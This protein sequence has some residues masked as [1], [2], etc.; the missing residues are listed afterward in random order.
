MKTRGR[1][2]APAM[3]SANKAIA[4]CA[5]AILACIGAL[6]F[7]DES[8]NDK[9]R[10]GV[11]HSYQVLEKLQT[12]RI[13]INQA[14]AGQRGYMLTG[15]DRYLE[16]YAAGVG[17]VRQDMIELPDLTAD[18]L[19][20]RDAIKRLDP[21]IEARLAELD[22]G[23]EVR[24]RSGLLAGV[25]AVTEGNAGELWME[26]IATHIAEMQQTEAELLNKRLET[27]AVST[28]TMKLVIVCG[29]ALA[30]LILLVKGFVIHWEIGRRN[31]AEQQLKH[32]N[33]RLERRTAQL[34]ETNIELESFAY[35]VA[36]DLRAPLRHIAGYASV[37]AEDYGPRL[38]AEGLRCLGKIGDGAEKMGGLVDDLLSLS[39]VGR[40]QLSRHD[41]PLDALLGQVVEDL[42]P[43]CS[44]RDIEWQIGDLFSAECDPG[45]MKQVFAN[46]L[47][48]AVKYTRKRN[49]AVIQVGQTMHNDE[50]VV[51]V[52]DNGVG[53]DM[54]YVGKLFGVFQ[55]LHKAR[56][57][58]GAGVGL[59]I[60]QRIIRKHGGR[61]W[62]EAELD[63]GATFFF[64]VGSPESETSKE[65]EFPIIEEEMH[66]ARS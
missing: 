19:H 48:N 8:R 46:L 60:A 20:E 56:D 54:Q 38:D 10:E 9:D 3:T 2:L 63:Q 45:L 25:E 11:S 15:Q 32:S 26:L 6:S 49:H 13:D 27:A 4:A 31:L 35:S 23:I 5:L 64:T 47:S 62:A 34:S 53:F 29:N 7:W 50:R 36:H 61:I 41:T 28:R 17:R 22:D 44:G 21:L 37:L 57:F 65:A 58:E 51:F 40:Q 52:R 18:N 33:E 42:A 66:V 59:A 43:E 30:I 12:V 39:K 55:R 16:L 24:K 14:E 1:S